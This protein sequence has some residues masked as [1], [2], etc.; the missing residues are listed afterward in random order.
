MAKPPKKPGRTKVIAVAMRSNG[1]GWSKCLAAQPC[2]NR[3]QRPEANICGEVLDVVCPRGQPVMHYSHL[4][5]RLRARIN[6][7]LS[8]AFRQALDLPNSSNETVLALQV[9]NL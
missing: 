2:R 9:A 5:F 7:L 6:R 3:W 4:T 1:T 8:D